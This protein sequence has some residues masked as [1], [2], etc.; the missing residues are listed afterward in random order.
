MWAGSASDRDPVGPSNSQSATKTAPLGAGITEGSLSKEKSS[1]K[2]NQKLFTIFTMGAGQ[3][4]KV[5][6]APSLA[7]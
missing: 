1:E 6:S 5:M 2:L 7:K 3:N 4:S